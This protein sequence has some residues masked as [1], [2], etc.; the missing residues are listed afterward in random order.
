MSRRRKSFH[1]NPTTATWLILGAAVAGV[2]A[3]ALFSKKASAAP[4]P[5]PGTLPGT[6]PATILTDTCQ[7]KLLELLP[8]AVLTAQ[9]TVTCKTNPQAQECLRGTANAATV[10]AYMTAA[11]ATC[12][13]GTPAYTGVL[14]ALPA[15]LPMPATACQKAYLE[16][17]DY[18]AQV[19]LQA[20]KAG[21]V[22]I[23][24]EVQAKAKEMAAQLDKVCGVALTL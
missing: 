20:Q 15:G 11:R 16:F 21:T 7:K 23:P 2:A 22:G 18:A 5:T 14:P 8:L 24:A 12:I 4:S 13:P 6:T 3:Y 17:L 9:D 19:E 1:R 10:T